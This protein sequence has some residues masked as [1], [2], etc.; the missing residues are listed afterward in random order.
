MIIKFFKK[1]K[2]FVAIVVIPIIISVLYFTFLAKDR[3]M[4]SSQVV[5]KKVDGED[6]SSSS[7][8][9]AAS[10]SSGLSM[11][12]GG[13]ASSSSEDTLY[14]E[15]FVTSH[16]ML[17]ILQQKLNW[18][19]HYSG[20]WWDPTYFV[21]SSAPQEDLLKYYQRMVTAT[22]DQTTG[23]LT[24]Q[25]QAFDKKFAE[26][27]LR[28]IM[29]ASD[30]FVNSI[31]HK[32][33]LEQVGFAEDQLQHARASYELNQLALLKFQGAHDLL[34]AG[35]AAQA[36]NDVI[37]KLQSDLSTEQAHERTLQS[38]L[39]SDSPQV[40]MSYL[41]IQAI[42]AQIA[43]EQRK[44]VARKAGSELN[45]VASEYATLQLNASIAQ[46]AYTSAASALLSA[47]IEAA[48]KLR[49]L[50]VIVNPN[51]PEESE[52]PKR[53]FNIFTIIILLLFIYGIVRFVLATI[54]D[55]RD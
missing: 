28:E 3:F 21:S 9:A 27:T 31:S 46:Q 55:H 39:S 34:D 41:K 29:V 30:Q 12:M 1:N 5:V 19:S 36:Q 49:A 48:K 40:R 16:D 25:V 44:L 23:T 35:L 4:S 38:T 43:A 33:A 10:A 14:V 52:F 2:L 18:S 22:Y 15:Q 17:D 26:Q 54:N 42:K 13:G 50:V 53:L 11:L 8:A 37:T 51:M 24:I 47:Q 20:I 7:S 45:V 6:S 32:L